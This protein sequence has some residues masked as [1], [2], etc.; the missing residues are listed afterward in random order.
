MSTPSNEFDT[1]IPVYNDLPEEWEESRT[2]LVEQLRE[3]TEG[4]NAREVA[5][6]IDTEQLTGGQFIKGTA[7]PPQFRN[8]FRKVID[9]GA[10]PN[11]TAKTVAHGI[12]T[13]AN[14]RIISRNAWANDP[15]ASDLTAAIPIPYVNVTT[16]TDGVQLDVDNTNVTIT[17]T[18]A[19]YTNYTSTFVILEYIQEP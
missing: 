7:N 13:T 8:I 16:P 14:T 3:M 12:T 10:L 9:F 6:Y 17:T 5:I 1:Y 19:N 11:T 4:I 18:T 2:F 15:G